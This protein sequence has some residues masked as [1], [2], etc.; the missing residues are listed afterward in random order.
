MRPLIAAAFISLA[1]LALG[2]LGGCRSARPER[3]GAASAVRPT[4]PGPLPRIPSA[5]DDKMWAR[6]RGFTVSLDM[7]AEPLDEAIKGFRAATMLDVRID[8]QSI[9]DAHAIKVSVMI[10]HVPEADALSLI[11]GT[12]DLT[13][14]VANGAVILLQDSSGQDST[15]RV[16]STG[17][18]ARPACGPS[19]L[20]P[21]STSDQAQRLRVASAHRRM[22]SGSEA[23]GPERHPPPSPPGGSGSLPGS[24]CAPRPAFAQW[25]R[26]R[27]GPV[28]R[29]SSSCPPVRSRR[30][31]ASASSRHAGPFP[32]APQH[33]G[34]KVIAT[35]P[36]HSHLSGFLALLV[37]AVAPL[38][39]NQEPAVP[40]TIRMTSRTFIRRVLPVLDTSP[41][42][43]RIAV[44]FMLNV[45][46]GAAGG[47]GLRRQL[48]GPQAR[49][50]SS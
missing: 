42:G 33:P 8:R 17:G 46:P 40:L 25:R 26:S 28:R 27:Q 34:R 4:R 31:I 21:P 48:H 5:T 22:R 30:R 9:P 37:L 44:R 6:L 3:A 45:A 23:A 38:C 43:R 49:R 24:S 19:L 11:C 14:R 20:L 35:L 50:V 13:Y 16:R 2:A 36:G 47:Q 32:D 41:L 39:G 29:R 7:H 18:R 10:A 1:A 12:A 15:V